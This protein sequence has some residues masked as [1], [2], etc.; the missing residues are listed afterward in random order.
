MRPWDRIRDI[1]RRA[2]LR[3]AVVVKFDARGCMAHDHVF[4]YVGVVEGFESTRLAG[5][6]ARIRLLKRGRYNADIRDEDLGTD[7]HPILDTCLQ[8]IRPGLFFLVR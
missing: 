1:K 2:E 6:A 5:T 8:K 4:V 3:D 7:L